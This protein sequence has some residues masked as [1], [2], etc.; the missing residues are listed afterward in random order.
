M[1]IRDCLAALTVFAALFAA[2][3]VGQSQPTDKAG[4]PQ[5]PR[6]GATPAE[7]AQF[8]QKNAEA[9]MQELQARM[10]RLS[11]LIKD[12]EPGDASRLLLAVR[13]AREELIIEQMK[14]V[15]ELIGQRDLT[16]AAE[17]EKQIIAKLEELKKLLLAAENDLILQ[18]ERLRKI[19]SALQKLDAA[20]KEQKRQEGQTG[21]MAKQQKDNKPVEP[22]KFNAAKQE[23]ERN[24]QATEAINQLMKALGSSGAKAG[25]ALGGACQSMSGAEGSLGGSKA[26]EAQPRQ[27]E[28]TKKLEQAKQELERERAKLLAEI[29]KQVKAQVLENLK[30]M[31][32]RQRLIRESTERLGERLMSAD[33][34][35]ALKAKR[36]ATAEQH[37]INIAD[38]TVSL[39]EQTQFSVAL[40]PALRSIQRRCVY[41]MSD[42]SAGRGDARN[43]AAQKQIE[44]DIEALIETMKDFA[45][46]GTPGQSNC[47][48]CN[49][50]KN[51]LLAELRVLRLL[52]LRVNEETKD[53]DG[54]RAAALASV[55]LPQEVKEKIGTVR[56]NQGQVHSATERLHKSVCPDCLKGEH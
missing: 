30:Q 6:P 31:L 33:R 13:K 10:F 41:V 50:S 35:A 47:Q 20:I 24:R 7:Q 18:L 37:V 40:P 25:A 39:I 12:T 4:K 23:Q 56:D 54:R 15:L 28:A 27:T 55:D 1:K 52:Q 44:K 42:L 19:E 8:L 17:G 22:S 51:K 48:G 34:E 21:E 46:R 14:E 29:E 32:D 45:P 11:E 36:L 3:V 5:A 53:A 2:P 38:Q 43:V 26:G 9:Q 16:R 49:G